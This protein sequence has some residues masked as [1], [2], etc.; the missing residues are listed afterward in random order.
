MAHILGL[1]CTALT[2][3]PPPNPPYLTLGM[4]D[5]LEVVLGLVMGVRG[6]AEGLLPS[7]MPLKELF[8][9][10]GGILG[11]QAVLHLCY[12]ALPAHSRCGRRSGVVQA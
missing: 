8:M 6:L 1:K 3:S 11:R 5:L 2:M 10:H 7:G 4:T 9:R 12:D